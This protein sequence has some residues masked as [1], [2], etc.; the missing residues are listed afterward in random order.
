MAESNQIQKDKY[1]EDL[2]ET[3]EI[4]IQAL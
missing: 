1:F 4:I 3:Q 2:K